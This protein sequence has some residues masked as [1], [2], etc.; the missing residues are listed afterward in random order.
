MIRNATLLNMGYGNFPRL[1]SFLKNL[2]YQVSI[3]GITD[4]FKASDLLIIPGIGNSNVINNMNKKSDIYKYILSYKKHQN[5][6]LGICLGMQIMCSKSSESKNKVNGLNIFP[7]NVIKLNDN[8]NERV[9]R[10]GWYES[11][12]TK[13]KKSNPIKL[14][15]AHSYY[16]DCN[17]NKNIH[18]VTRHNNKT[19]PAIIRD[20]NIIGLQFHPELSGDNGVDIFQEVMAS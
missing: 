13:N 20:N 6:I 14:Y 8:K 12:F 18:M 2:G 5:K 3:K 11:S 15:Y 16:V 1:T 4:S 7:Y 17:I 10:I 19:I 9:P